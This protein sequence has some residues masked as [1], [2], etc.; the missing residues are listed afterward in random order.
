MRFCFKDFGGEKMLWL[1]WR[2]GLESHRDENIVSTVA[3]QTMCKLPSGR[4]RSYEEAEKLMWGE[5]GKESRVRGKQR[6][7]GGRR[8]CYLRSFL[9]PM[10]PLPPLSF[11]LCPYDQSSWT[12]ASIC[13]FQSRKVLLTRAFSDCQG[14]KKYSTLQPGIEKAAGSRTKITNQIIKDYE[15]FGLP[16]GPVVRLI[17]QCITKIFRLLMTWRTILMAPSLY[18]DIEDGRAFGAHFHGWH[19]DET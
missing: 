11:S 4:S 5:K 1:V 19:Q 14:L 16:C 9:N 17:T 6:S 2:L 12:W 3:S 7:C 15:K 10:N 13:S 18:H 8:S